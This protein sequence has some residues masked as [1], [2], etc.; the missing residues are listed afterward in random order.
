MKDR[1]KFG[2]DGLAYVNKRK[3]K[4]PTPRVT[5]SSPATT[6]TTTTT[7]TTAGTTTRTQSRTLA[8]ERSDGTAEKRQNTRSSTPRALSCNSLRNGSGHNLYST[9]A[10]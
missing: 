4:Y 1:L 3:S 2:M 9:Q 8:F 10:F 5:H 7:T 6:T